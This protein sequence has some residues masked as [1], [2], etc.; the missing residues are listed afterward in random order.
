MSLVDEFGRL[1]T[2]RFAYAEANDHDYE[3]ALGA[4]STRVGRG[5]GV[6]ELGFELHRVVAGFIDGHAWVEPYR[7]AEGALP[8]RLDPLG[9]RVVAV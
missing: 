6:S 9:D 1:L 7:L 8:I 3:S 4:L 5:V 2:D